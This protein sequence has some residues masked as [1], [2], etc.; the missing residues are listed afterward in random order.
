MKLIKKIYGFLGSEKYKISNIGL[1]SLGLSDICSFKCVF[2][3]FHSPFLQRKLG[4]KQ[5]E[6]N[7][8]KNLIIDNFSK[9]GAIDIEATGEFL[10]SKKTIEFIKNYNGKINNLAT[11]ASL[12]NDENIELL[13]SIKDKIINKITISINTTDNN[14]YK[15]IHSTNK[16]LD[17][18]LLDVKKMIKKFKLINEYTPKIEL[19]MVLMQSNLH[20]ME[21]F[22]QIAKD[23]SVDIVRFIPLLTIPNMDIL[24]GEMNSGKIFNYKQEM[25][26]NFQ[27]ELNNNFKKSQLI[28]LPNEE[29]YIM[30]L[31]EDNDTN[32]TLSCCKQPYTYMQLFGNGDYR[33]CC[34]SNK[35]F[36]NIFKEKITNFDNLINSKKMISLRKM[37][38]SNKLHTYCESAN[39]SYVKAYNRKMVNKNV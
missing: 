19:S 3:P 33:A 20:Q 24:V 12:L 26:D 32:L 13:Y 39:C 27:D 7:F 6:I 16:E 23:L 17:E 18:T 9:I 30:K 4:Y 15:D 2:C 11:N 37:I 29:I 5:E 38:S 36:G 8:V 34:Y 22:T 31:E 28:F 1:I 35:E 25:L 21:S 10:A 14:L